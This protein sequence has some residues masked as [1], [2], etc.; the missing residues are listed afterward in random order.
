VTTPRLWYFVG[1]ASQGGSVP[2]VKGIWTPFY[3]PGGW[4]LAWREGLKPYG[5]PPFSVMSDCNVPIVW[6]DWTGKHPGAPTQCLIDEL[7]DTYLLGLAS[8]LHRYQGPVL[9]HSGAMHNSTVKPEQVVALLEQTGVLNA[10]FVRYLTDAQTYWCQD[11]AGEASPDTFG[12]NIHLAYRLQHEAFKVAIEG[13]TPD[14][15]AGIM[16]VRLNLWQRS[17]LYNMVNNPAARE[18]IAPL[19]D[20]CEHVTWIDDATLKTPEEHV[21]AAEMVKAG[22]VISHDLGRIETIEDMAFL[23]S[24]SRPMSA[25]I[26]ASMTADQVREIWGVAQ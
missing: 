8:F 4:D 18:G 13:G 11:A 1:T 12:Q 16:P 25:A 6:Q 21:F 22:G 5:I 20:D 26:S 3:E 14:R 23:A 2:N 7:P 19:G 9:L 24:A 10:V 17:A 15:Y